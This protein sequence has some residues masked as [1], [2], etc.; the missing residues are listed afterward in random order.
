M[1]LAASQARLLLL[2]ARRNDLEFRAQMITQQK[3]ALAM[4]TEQFAI[5][6]SEALSDKRLMFTCWQ[7]GNGGKNDGQMSVELSYDA[8]SSGV[9]GD[10]NAASAYLVVDNSTGKYVIPSN[11]S[12]EEQINFVDRNGL[13]DKKPYQCCPT[14]GT[15][16]FGEKEEKTEGEGENAVTTIVVKANTAKKQEDAYKKKCKEF[17]QNNLIKQDNLDNNALF[18][19]KLQNGS[20][21]LQKRTPNQSDD[22]YTGYEF[23][24]VSLAGATNIKDVL[25]TENDPQAAAAYD[26]QTKMIQSKDK[27]LDVQ[28]K[29][30]E[31]QLEAVKSEQESVKSLIKDRAGKDFKAFG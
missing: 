25:F 19:T 22:G 20:Y 5:A 13:V 30:V 11:M 9:F 10:A 2:T 6:Y 1:G 16:Q 12:E 17:A 21:V 8:I 4:E 7:D 28:L 15:W 29:Q 18:Q 31:T 23:S 26:S 3:L 27:M 14:G 24:N